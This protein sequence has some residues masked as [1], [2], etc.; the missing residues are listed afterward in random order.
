MSTVGDIK[1]A[2]NKWAPF[3]TAEGF[4]NVGVLIGDD[5]L[6]V[7]K[8]VICLDVTQSVCDEAAGMGAELIISHHP[9]VFEP[10]KSLSSESVVYQLV[11]EGISVL[12]AHTNLDKASGGVNETLIDALGFA[13]K[14]AV[15]GTDSLLFKCEAEF[16]CGEELAKHVKSKLALD[17]VR[18]Y[19]AGFPIE[20][21]AVCCGSGGSFLP[22]V[23]AEG[24]DAFITGDVKHNVAVDA[25]NYGI[26]L[27]DAGHYETEQMIVS[28]I[29]EYL[30]PLFPDVEFIKAESCKPL[31]KTV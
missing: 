15:D 31:F 26:T 4:D 10:L 9:V 18:F 1:N 14:K 28:K 30:K 5:F 29:F 2:M 19:D 25:E 21:V 7:T 23:V 27:I 11:S 6:E 20:N 16:S 12:S 17:S 13:D 22:L 8:C 3:E 24:I